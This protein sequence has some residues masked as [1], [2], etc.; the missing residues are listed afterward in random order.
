[1]LY[2]PPPHAPRILDETHQEFLGVVYEKNSHGYFAK[3]HRLLHRAV[4][5]FF[6]G[7]IPKGYVVHHQDWNPDNNQIENLRSMTRAEHIEIHR[8]KVERVCIVCGKTFLACANKPRKFCS[9][10][11]R[12]KV[13]NYRES[14]ERICVV[15][16]KPFMT[17]KGLKKKC[18]SKSCWHRLNRKLHP[19]PDRKVE[20]TCVVCGK[21][22]TTRKYVGSKCCLRSSL[23]QAYDKKHDYLPNLQQTL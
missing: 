23:S 16:G 6:N 8:M 18:C 3:S 9:N 4:W 13:R 22:F 7:E 15:C 11:C 20:R 21:T 10:R 1:M 17:K 19:Q 12:D 14:E 2:L 5:K